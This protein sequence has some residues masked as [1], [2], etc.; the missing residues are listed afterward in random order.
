MLECLV[1]DGPYRL[2]VLAYVTFGSQ[3]QSFKT[4]SSH[5]VHLLFMEVY[6]QDRVRTN[7]SE[8]KVVKG[9]C[10][11]RNIE[12]P[13]NISGIKSRLTAVFQWIYGLV[14]EKLMF[15]SHEK[16]AMSTATRD[17]QFVSV[18]L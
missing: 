9:S 4:T 14:W 15:D 7:I 8:Q 3:V 12:G 10:K 11:L 17:R 2:K 13:V 16:T 6:I 5:H 18:T 1:Y